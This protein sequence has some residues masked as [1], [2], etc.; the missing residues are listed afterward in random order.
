[1]VWDV[2]APSSASGIGVS[3]AAAKTMIQGTQ[4]GAASPCRWL[5]WGTEVFGAR[6]GPRRRVNKVCSQ[7][8][9]WW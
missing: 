7:A 6:T 3:R 2:P 4:Q 9:W 8:R 5:G 1:M